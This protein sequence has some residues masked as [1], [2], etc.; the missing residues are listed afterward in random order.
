MCAG[1]NTIKGS[2]RVLFLQIEVTAPRLT[3][4]FF[5]LSLKT[6]LYWKNSHVRYNGIRFRSFVS[7]RKEENFLRVALDF[8]ILE[9]VTKNFKKKKKK[10]RSK[11]FDFTRHARF[12]ELLRQHNLKR[13]GKNKSLYETNTI[14]RFT[15][16]L[17]LNNCQTKNKSH[18]PLV[19]FRYFPAAL[20][21]ARR[22]LN[23]VKIKI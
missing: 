3:G 20:C 12:V 7:R 1:V 14:S 16:L 8:G 23:I 9:F 18:S 2:A 21:T 22:P 17:F 11:S 4:F 5:L 10:I 6:M 13:L 19:G 15:S